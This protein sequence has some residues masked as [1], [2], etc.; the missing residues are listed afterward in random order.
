M[1]TIRYNYLMYVT[2]DGKIYPNTISDP[3]MNRLEKKVLEE[4]LRVMELGFS[5]YFRRAWKETEEELVW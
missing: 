4:K 5:W 3:S 2:K 1:T